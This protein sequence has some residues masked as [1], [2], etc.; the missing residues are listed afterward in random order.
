M[1]AER[2]PNTLLLVGIS[3]LV[4]LIAAIPIGVWSA[5]KPYSKFDYS[6]TT[7]TFI[8]QSIPVYWLG[9]GIN[10][11][12]LCDHQES[13]HRDLFFCGRHEHSGQK[14]GRPRS[15]L[16]FGFARYSFKFGMDRMVFP[17]SAFKHVGRFA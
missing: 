14:R 17:F 7:V 11:Y 3:F 6:M 4:T 2:I 16:A 13:S 5:R 9:T 10:D 8:G 1:I 12:F 15:T